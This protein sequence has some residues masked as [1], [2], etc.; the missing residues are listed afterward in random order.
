MLEL[1]GA[2]D[3]D[4][5][6]RMRRE[7]QP[8]DGGDQGPADGYEEVASSYEPILIRGQGAN[9]RSRGRGNPVFC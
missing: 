1:V 4:R 7:G 5:A 9:C 3:V 6:R 8:E 2:S